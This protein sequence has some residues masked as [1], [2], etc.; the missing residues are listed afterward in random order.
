LY[1]FILVGLFQIK[2]VGGKN[3]KIPL[4]LQIFS[5]FMFIGLLFTLLL[6]ETKGKTLEEIVE[7]NENEARKRKIKKNSQSF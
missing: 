1:F 7:H 5:A 6:P 3:A 4:I 2:D